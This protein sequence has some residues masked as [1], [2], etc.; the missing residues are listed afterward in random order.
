MDWLGDV[1]VTSK[2]RVDGAISMPDIFNL[3]AATDR[4]NCQTSCRHRRSVSFF[5]AAEEIRRF[6]SLHAPS[7]HGD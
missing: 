5:A 7:L 4:L 2:C 3:Q 6:Y 1:T